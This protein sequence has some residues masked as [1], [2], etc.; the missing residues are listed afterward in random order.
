M[1]SKPKPTEIEG[2][3]QVSSREATGEQWRQPRLSEAPSQT[4]V[5]Q[6]LGDT[7]QITSILEKGGMG[8][9]YRGEHLRLRRPVAIKVLA[10]HLSE[11][12]AALSRF[13]SEAE[14]VS[15]LHHPHVVHIL[16]FDTTELGDPYIVMELLSGETL[17]RRLMR[18]QVLDLREAAQIVMQTAGGLLVAHAAGIVHRDL[19]PD[20]VFLL[21]MQD[22]SI[23]VKLLDFGISKRTAAKARVTGE[24]DVLGT[25]NY[26]APEQITKAA[27]AD[28]RADQWSLAAITYEMIAGRNPFK[29]ENIGRTLAKV[30]SEDPPSLAQAAPGISPGITEVVAR[31]LA[32]APEQRFAN[33]VEFAEAFVRAAGLSLNTSLLPFGGEP[34]HITRR[35][36][37]PPLAGIM[38]PNDTVVQTT[39]L[40][41]EVPRDDAF[42]ETEPHLTIPNIPSSRP[43]GVVPPIGNQAFP[44]RHTNVPAVIS[45]APSPPP[46]SHFMPP[47]SAGPGSF[48]SRLRRSDS[49]PPPPMVLPD[50]RDLSLKAPRVPDYNSLYPQHRKAERT[51][52]S[53]LIPGGT[54]PP[55]APTTAQVGALEKIRA[56]LDDIRQAVTFG[57][58]QRALSK[59]RQA[60]QLAQLERY[61]DAKDLLAEAT[62]LLRPILL[63]AVGGLQRR[64]VARHVQTV[65]GASLSPEHLFLLSRMEGTLTVEELIDVSPLSAP[66]TLGILLDSRDE[67]Y[68]VIE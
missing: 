58:S 37:T 59:A 28:H 12:Q 20:N 6:V 5:G 17:A 13:R 45:A 66:E 40:P 60:V 10:Q 35:I 64:V 1:S 52:A 42:P 11:D 24:F 31:G 9:V 7:Y 48:N 29:S 23:F 26:M 21:E 55:E 3:G 65:R 30:L 46:Q 57:E 16:D 19:K 4:L 22:R 67:G 63:R 33:I 62:E 34:S 44:V 8:T 61:R 15:Q 14:I 36:I 41:D 51:L 38:P 56:L 49:E 27:Q 25:P 32:K 68:L 18:D 2:V 39:P 50:E 53:A 47:V 43:P 54:T